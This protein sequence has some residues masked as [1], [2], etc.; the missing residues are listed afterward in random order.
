MWQF[1][2][3]WQFKL[4]RSV[5]FCRVSNAKSVITSINTTYPKYYFFCIQ[6]I[7]FQFL[8]QFIELLAVSSMVFFM[9][10]Y[11]YNKSKSGDVFF[12]VIVCYWGLHFHVFLFSLKIPCFVFLLFHCFCTSTTFPPCSKDYVVCLLLLLI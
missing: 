11:K 8:L 4:D 3:F 6:F 2:L 5:R 10:K 9:Y 12:R 7:Y 1:F